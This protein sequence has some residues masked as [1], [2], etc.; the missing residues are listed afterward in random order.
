DCVS[1]LYPFLVAVIVQAPATASR[2]KGV[3]VEAI[4]EYFFPSNPVP[5][6]STPKPDPLQIKTEKKGCQNELSVGMPE[7]CD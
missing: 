3:F 5:A 7:L 4:P 6:A 1:S 2:L